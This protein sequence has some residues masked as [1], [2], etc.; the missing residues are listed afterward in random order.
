M[1]SHAFEAIDLRPS[2]A[3]LAFGALLAGC[4]ARDGATTQTAA[5]VNKDEITIHQV[6]A[7]LSQQPPVEPEQAKEAERQALERLIHR[8]LA[9]QKAADLKFDRDP[10]VVQAIESSR[11]DILA[12][13]Y[14]DKLG[15]AAARPSAAE[16]K[17]YYDAHPALFAQRKIYQVQE[18]A[19]QA[20]AR[21]IEALKAALP[22]MKSG[23]DLVA[24]LKAND[25]KFASGK[26]VRAAEQIPL[27]S[28]PAL[29]KLAEGQALLNPTAGGVQ[30]IV[31]LGSRSQPVDEAQASRA[32]E[33]FLIN[34]Q[35]RKIVADDLKNL[36]AAARI[37]YQGRFAASTPAREAPAAAASPAEVAAS[38][39][40]ALDRSVNETP[41]ANA[42]APGASGPA[43]GAVDASIINKGLGLK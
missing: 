18:V 17:Q 22:A 35:K 3:A 1:P 26:A 32:I 38:A 6:A 21:Q 31:L 41:V 9:V 19:I 40:A 30:A 4:G 11:M 16:I 27:S 15:E 39:A 23:D 33:Q 5:R 14:A 2:A 13:A 43:T 10:K 28:L 8:Q 37:E 34:E 20:D 36:R 24:H 12:R 42:G 29:S 7:V 25:I